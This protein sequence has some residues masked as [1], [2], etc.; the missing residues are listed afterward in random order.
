MKTLKLPTQKLKSSKQ[1]VP[2]VGNYFHLMA[3]LL[4]YLCFACHNF[5][6]KGKVKTKKID[7]GPCYPYVTNRFM[8]SF[9]Q[10]LYYFLNSHYSI[11]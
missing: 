4:L 2:D 6:Q 9:M 1:S 7:V 11:M 8:W 3:T 5:V 10:R